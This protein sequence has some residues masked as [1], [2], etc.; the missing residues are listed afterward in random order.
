MRSTKPVPWKKGWTTWQSSKYNLSY[1]KNILQV[2]CTLDTT[3]VF[4]TMRPVRR[5]AVTTSGDNRDVPILN[6]AGQNQNRWTTP[7]IYG[8]YFANN[9]GSGDMQVFSN[10]PMRTMERS[11]AV[12]LSNYGYPAYECGY[13]ISQKLNRQ[14]RQML[15]NTVSTMS[16]LQSQPGEKGLLR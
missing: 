4:D 14:S 13:T 3:G 16:C 5:N 15:S 10:C 11:E 8:K 7:N 6:C 2:P 1:F 12:T 9:L